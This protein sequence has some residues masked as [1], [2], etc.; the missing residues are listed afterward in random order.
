MDA[1]VGIIEAFTV[2][3]REVELA[4]CPAVGVKVYV[5][6]PATAVE[7]VADQTPVILLLEDVGKIGGVAP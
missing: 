7:T 5:V 4:H 3:S 1:K 6:V 2:I